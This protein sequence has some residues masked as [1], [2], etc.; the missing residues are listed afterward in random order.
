VTILE[1][2]SARRSGLLGSVSV[3]TDSDLPEVHRLVQQSPW[4]NAVMAGRIAASGTIRPG[5]I[6]GTIFGIRNR[7]GIEA[8]VFTGGAVMP[9]GGDEACWS[10]L[11]AA[12]SMR[13]RIC[14]SIVGQA[15]AVA[16]MWSV[17][18]HRWGPARSIRHTQ[19]LLV[20]DHRPAV[21]SDPAVRRARPADLERYVAASAAMFTDELGVSPYTS[22]GENAYRCRITDLINAG[23]AFARFD[24]RGQV[25]FKADLGVVTDQTCQIQGVWVRPDLRGRGVA[26]AAMATVIRH[27][28]DLAPTASLYVNDFNV[29]GLRLYTKLGMRQHATMATVLL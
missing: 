14:S 12:I 15:D 6:G 16:T 26:T 10:A 4:V 7:G 5:Y 20:L 8:A 29:A 28:L 19:P 27:A 21:A 2:A 25:E 1:S 18:D 9:I 22:P 24:A 17:L 11:A 13:P 23:H 3:L